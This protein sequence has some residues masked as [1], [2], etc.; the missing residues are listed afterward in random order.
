MHQRAEKMLGFLMELLGHRPGFFRRQPFELVKQLELEH[1]LVRV[2]LDFGPLARDLRFVDLAFGL[3]RQVR[4]GAHRERAGQRARQ[5]GREHDFAAAGIARHTR[6]D[7]EH[8]AQTVVHAVD[9]VA[10]PAGAAHVPAFPMEDRVERRSGCRDLAAGQRPQDD[11][12][13]ALIEHGFFGD[14]SILWIGE[15]RQ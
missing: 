11:R 2:L 3:R 10:D 1:L 8:R 15:P 13:V 6:D 5:A 7:P 4:A 14:L 9:R 12:M